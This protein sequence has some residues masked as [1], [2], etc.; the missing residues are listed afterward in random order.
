[1]A[2]QRDWHNSICWN[3]LYNLFQPEAMLRQ[4]LHFLPRSVRTELISFRWKLTA[5]AA[6]WYRC[7]SHVVINRRAN[8]L[9]LMNEQV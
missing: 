2:C 3:Y 9:Q 1:M 8:S 6:S 4:P 7:T 5:K